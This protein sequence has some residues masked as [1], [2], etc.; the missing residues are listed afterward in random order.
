MSIKLFKHG[1]NTIL[2]IISILLS[3]STVISAF[4][5]LINPVS[6]AKFALLGML[7]PILLILIILLLGVLLIMRRW[8]ISIIPI[9]TIIITIQSTLTYFPF[10]IVTTTNAPTDITFTLL[11]YNVLNFDEY[12]SEYKS[13]EYDRTAQYIIDMDADIVALQEC[14]EN[15]LK[16]KSKKIPP[17]QL[18]IITE[19][20]PYRHFTKPDIAILS[21]YPITDIT[22]DAP[23]LDGGSFCSS[24]IEHPSE[25]ITL[26]NLHLQSIMLKKEDKEL[27]K[28]V[29]SLGKDN[30]KETIEEV[31]TQLLWKLTTAFRSRAIQAETLRNYTDS[32]NAT[33]L[34]IC[35]DFND[36]PASYAYRT[37]KGDM[38][39]AYTQCAFW[40]TITYHADRFYFRI[41]Q[42]FYHGNIQATNIKRGK[43]K[44]SDHYPLLT[45]FKFNQ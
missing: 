1:V 27:Y 5:G 7:F 15:L 13:D 32:I 17:E 33:N 44:S 2:I 20:Y 3:I 10:N 39:D 6:N 38:T 9:A 16:E 14:A 42:V 8:K 12:Q 43:V 21:K 40:P 30:N 28:D 29:T 24:I 34:I 45:T 31:R 11:T 25:K 35:G 36:T 22:T 19:K 26:V 23:E 37:I 4:S 18:A 41:D